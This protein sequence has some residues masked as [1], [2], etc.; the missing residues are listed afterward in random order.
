MSV[1]MNVDADAR[2][3]RIYDGGLLEWTSNNRELNLY[4]G[5][6]IYVNSGGTLDE[7]GRN[8][9]QVWFVTD[10]SDYV[11]QNEGT[12]TIDNIQARNSG[13]NITVTG[14]GDITANIL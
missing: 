6:G 4:N 8:N 14:A 2:E 7:N 3:V 1:S 9:A 5:G 11:I 10:G 12:I 13:G